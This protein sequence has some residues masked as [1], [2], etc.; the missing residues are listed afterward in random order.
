M[1]INP[2]PV[3]QQP[4]WGLLSSAL[5]DDVLFTWEFV[6]ESKEDRFDWA[7][8][9]FPESMWLAAADAAFEKAWWESHP[10][11]PPYEDPTVKFIPSYPLRERDRP[12]LTRIEIGMARL[13]FSYF[14]ADLGA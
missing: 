3:T 8:A 12:Q 4:E 1:T 10:T 13:V 5:Q 7:S 6:K 9:D 2:N 14:L 11:T